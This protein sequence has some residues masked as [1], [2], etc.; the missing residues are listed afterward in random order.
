MAEQ[1][2]HKL[3]G[4]KLGTSYPCPAPF[5]LDQAS[6]RLFLLLFLFSLSLFGVQKTCTSFGT[7]F[8]KLEISIY[9]IFVED[10]QW[11]K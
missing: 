9:T 10:A 6:K 7:R 5:L 2:T 8:E 4:P 11:F 3:Q 1:S